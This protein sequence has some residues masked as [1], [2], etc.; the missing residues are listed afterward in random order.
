MITK[1]TLEKATFETIRRGTTVLS[2]DVY[3]AFEKAIATETSATAKNGL[4]RTLESMRMSKQRDNLL[5]AD[6]GWP[7]FYV[8]LGEDCEVEGGF[9]AIEEIVKSQVALATKKGY[10]RAT[11][12]HPLTG[13]DPGNNVGMNIPDVTYRFVKGKDLEI[14]YVAKGGGSECFGGTRHRMVAFAD[15]LAGIKKC[16][17]E[18]FIAATRAGAICPPSILGIGIGGTANLAANLAKEAACLRPIGSHHPE[19]DIRALE[20]E[21]KEAI[22]GLGIGILGAGGDVSVLAVHIEYA[23]THI[24]GVAV[25]MSSNCMVARRAATRVYGDNRMEILKTPDWFD[26]GEA[27]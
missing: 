15:G 3:E 7:V 23:H 22:N 20:E 11:M 24:A 27:Q 5:C 26:R 10:L 13:A 8:K 9:T 25:A 1:E 21:L 18:N 2:D 4:E 17:L 6:T 16:V 19:A 12:K 14:S